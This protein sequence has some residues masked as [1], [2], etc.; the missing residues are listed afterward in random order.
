MSE[1][2]VV[3][4]DRRMIDDF[5][6]AVRTKGDTRRVRA[7]GPRPGRFIPRKI[8]VISIDYCQVDLY[9]DKL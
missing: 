8:W 9:I 5:G 6:A 1:L 2:H 7:N 4:N 3:R